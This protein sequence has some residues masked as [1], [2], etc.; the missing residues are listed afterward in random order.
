MKDTPESITHIKSNS[1]DWFIAGD[2]ETKGPSACAC[3]PIAI[4]DIPAV[5]SLPPQMGPLHVCSPSGHPVSCAIKPLFFHLG[6]TAEVT[7][8]LQVHMYVVYQ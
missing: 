4:Q 5:V 2:E 8:S 7:D 6:T 3:C 1:C